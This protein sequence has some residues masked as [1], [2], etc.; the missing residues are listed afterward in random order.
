M[1]SGTISALS[2]RSKCIVYSSLYLCVVITCILTLYY[3]EIYTLL[4]LK[5]S[6]VYVGSNLKISEFIHTEEEI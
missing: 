2:Y 5:F 6:D 3:S 1:T 4:K